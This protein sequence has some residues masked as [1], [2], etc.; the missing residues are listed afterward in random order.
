MSGQ[1]GEIVCTEDDFNQLKNII[2]N[3]KPRT[4]M[5]NDELS[6]L[7]LENLQYSEKAQT[8][9]TF[10]D[11]PEVYKELEYLS[12]QDYSA[13]KEMWN[14]IPQNIVEFDNPIINVRFK[15]NGI[16][17]EEVNEEEYES[18][19]ST[20]EVFE[21]MK[22]KYRIF[23]AEKYGNNYDVSGKVRFVLYTD[24]YEKL[25]KVPVILVT[26]QGTYQSTDKERK[27]IEDYWKEHY[28][29]N[30]IN[31]MDSS[32]SSFTYIDLIDPKTGEEFAINPHF[33][34]S[35][36]KLRKK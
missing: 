34:V 35:G 22:D 3:I 4:S 36:I 20:H 32:Q 6:G 21:K 9:L 29:N 8:L 23:L 15:N 7:N 26:M 18:V 25:D 14:R 16:F 17:F 19:I 28:G 12:K 1:K 33:E 24:Y 30:S 11:E 10:A 13:I 5:Q 27:T 2:D 31:N